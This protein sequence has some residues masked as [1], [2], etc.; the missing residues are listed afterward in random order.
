MAGPSPY[1]SFVAS[2]YS[3]ES[4]VTRHPHARR[5]W[6]ESTFKIDERGSTVLREIRAGTATFLTMSYI[7]V[8]NSR[9]LGSPNS[10]IPHSD[11]AIG[12]ALSSA[13]AS[14]FCGFFANIPFALAPGLGLSAYVS[15]DLGDPAA[16][17][18]RGAL[19]A[20]AVSGALQIVLGYIGLSGYLMRG[21]PRSVQ[22]GTVIGMGLLLAFIGLQDVGIVAAAKA[23]QSGL[24]TTG[25]NAYGAPA[26]MAALG[27]V[28][29]A[30]L[31]SRQVPGAV[32]VAVFAVAL[33]SVVLQS[34]PPP[35]A[36]FGVPNPGDG[37]LA[38]D[39][40]MLRFAEHA[41]AIVAF[42]LVAIF[43]IAGV[44]IGLAGP[45]ELEVEHGEPVG[46]HYAFVAAG[47]GTIVGAAFGS[48]PV[49]V[50]LESAAGI[51]EGG[52]TGLTAVTAGLWF[53][54]S[55]FAAPLI[56]FVPQTATAPILVFIG[57]CMLSQ[58][59]F[60]D[61]DEPIE[62]VP[63]FVT[64]TAIP[65]CFSVPQGIA[66]GAIASSVLL[67]SDRILTAVQ[68]CLCGRGGGR[69]GGSARGDYS[70]TD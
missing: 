28:I 46:A 25:D 67:T 70:G 18:W 2:S 68:D 11:V 21:T 26:A 40:G 65:F 60:V 56:D 58:A 7:I 55:L 35:E 64:L 20:C 6:L 14:I 66:I 33:L 61:W 23:G 1:G 9:L 48:S 3:S 8:V 34:S 27:L 53:A 13:V 4:H 45:A 15:V 24:L 38:W 44:L 50:H 59:K 37:F 30:L 57:A 32:L 52:R 41:P 31:S 36:V 5:S 17:A 54:L 39:F 16:G 69:G 47:L 29:V 22:S 62:A 63:A 51:H 43:D 12:T 19:A 49:I 42:L 10:S